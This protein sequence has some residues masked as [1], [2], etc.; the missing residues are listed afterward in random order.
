MELWKWSLQEV[1]ETEMKARI[2][3]VMT[4]MKTFDLIFCCC[5]GERILKQKDN[6]SK[7]LQRKDISA[8]EGQSLESQ[9]VTVMKKSRNSEMYELF[10]ERVLKRQTQLDVLTPKLPRK[11]KMPKYFQNSSNPQD[12][13]LFHDTPKDRYR[14]IYF[15]AFDRTINCIEQKFDQPG[16]KIYVDLQE[17]LLKSIKH[18][19][20]T[21]NRFAAFM[22]EISI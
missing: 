4:V 10:W 13:Y 9:V 16:Y 5:L 7:T 20:T 18:G 8:A 17:V 22:L 12:T 14:E 11:R 19:K 15:E 6:L 21:S 2:R 1:K 3:E